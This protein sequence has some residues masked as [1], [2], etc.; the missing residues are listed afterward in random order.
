[1]RLNLFSLIFVLMAVV[2]SSFAQS[3]VTATIDTGSRMASMSNGIVSINISSKGQVSSLS[4][5]GKS[6]LSNGG[7]FYFSYNDQSS[8]Y[9]LNPES[10]RI[11]KQNDDYAEVAYTHTNGSL[12]L[13]QGFVMLKVVSG[14]YS[15]V[16]VKGTTTSTNLREMRIVYRVDPNRFDYGYVSDRM[17]GYLPTVDVMK[18]VN[19]SPIMDAT[20]QL[21][22]GS[23]Y[24]KYNWANYNILD[25]VH[26]IMSDTEGIWAI[27]VSNEYMNGGPM[28]QELTVH[29]TNKTPLV[30]QMLQGEHFGASAQ[31]YTD[32]DEKIYGPFF[33]YVNSGADH[34]TMI[35][36]AKQQASIQKVQ[37]PFQWFE[38]SLY[39][40][41][42]ST[43]TGKLELPSSLPSEG[44]QVVL[45]QPGSDIYIQGKDYMF[46]GLT[47]ENGNFTIKNVR[48]GS[49][50]LYAY[51]TQGEITG[52]L[53]IDNVSVSGATS[54]FGVIPWHPSK[55]E[56]MLWRIGENDR[57]SDGYR[58]S[59]T[60]RNYGLYELPPANHDYVIGTSTMDKDWYYTQT[61]DGTWTITFNNDQALSG[62]A[63]LTAS[64]AGV[65]NSPTVNVYVNGSKKGTWSFSNEASIYRS[66]VLSGKHTVK[67]VTFPASILVQGENT[68]KLTMSNVGNRGGVMYDCI[69]LEAGALAT[70]ISDLTSNKNTGL[71]ATSYPNPFSTQTTIELDASKAQQVSVAIFNAQGQLMKKLYDDWCKAGENR[72][73]WCPENQSFGT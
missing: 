69:K 11:Q 3:N 39:P 4:H 41:D 33:I 67:T 12:I 7:K 8:Y 61:K 71:T 37:W 46:W 59:D 55:Y 23:I 10:I 31:N 28:K 30:L 51:A 22:D 25:S 66:A 27:P 44:I 18:A 47:D 15:Y 42:R 1:M 57:L 40:P 13:E 49:Y 45:A 38:N 19:D 73:V 64:I 35:E 63:T 14:L 58:Y 32:G 68:F 24:T 20:Y 54:Y 9:E 56:Q 65:A 36:D 60:L 5:N 48:Q 17:Q 52:E 26:G 43:V 34:N 29:A 2:S 72:F 70:G 53:K 62:N 6:L 16:T 21:P 50:T